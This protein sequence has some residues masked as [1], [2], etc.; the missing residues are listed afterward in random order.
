MMGGF[1]YAGSPLTL[2]EALCGT[3]ISD[4]TVISDDAGMNDCSKA[5]LCRSG[6]VT[7][8]LTTHTGINEGIAPL[9][10]SG[11]IQIEYIPQ[12]TFCERIRAGGNGL[13]GILTPTGVGTLVEEGKKKVEINGKEYL[14]EL[15]IHADV[16]LIRAKKADK[17]GNLVMRGVSINHNIDMATAADLVIAEVDEIVDV[18]HILPE[19]VC[20]P[21]LYVDYIVLAK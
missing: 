19:D 16:A 13:G 11:A 14:L 21:G 1:G 15:P 7:K 12:G 8:M 2:A 18:G 5:E 17:L 20:V 4:L 9:Y 10:N 3:D 6:K